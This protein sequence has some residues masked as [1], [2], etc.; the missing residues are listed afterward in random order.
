V[1]VNSC[2]IRWLSGGRHRDGSLEPRAAA[3]AHVALAVDDEAAALVQ[4]LADDIGEQALDDAAAV[5]PDTRRARDRGRA[6]VDLDRAP[7]TIGM[8]ARGPPRRSEREGEWERHR[9]A[10]TL[11]PVAELLDLVE[12]RGVHEPAGRLGRVDDGLGE[13]RH[14]RRDR[15]RRGACRD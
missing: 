10:K 3:D 12:Q 5:E 7:A 15:H 13:A 6:E 8:R 9:A 1:T 2:R 4:Q 14:H 11:G